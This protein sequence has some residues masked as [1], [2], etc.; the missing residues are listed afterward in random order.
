MKKFL[1]SLLVLSTVFI[2]TI[3]A[4]A[5]GSCSYF[6]DLDPQIPKI[7]TNV[8]KIIQVA[9]P[10]IIIVFGMMDFM[11]AVMAQKDDEIKKAQGIFI[12]R[13]LAGALVFLVIVI[14]KFVVNFVSAENVSEIINCIDY[15]ISYE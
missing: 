8:V 15:F 6:A 10:I 1:S 12:K 14:V 11:K 4:K 2:G 3:Q 9:V 7:V 5:A 13:L